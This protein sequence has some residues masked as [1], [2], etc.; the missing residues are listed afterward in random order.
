[1][2]EENNIPDEP[3]YIDTLEIENV[4]RVKA[5][6]IKC[7]DKA[8]TVVG[9]RN[10]QGKSTT[11]DSVAYA[12][13]GERFRPT[14]FRRDGALANPEIK[15]TLSNGLI[16]ERKGKNADLKVTDP[17]GALF[18]QALLKEIIPLFALDLPRFMNSTSKEKA[19]ILLQIIGIGDELTRLDEKEQ[20]LYNTRHSHGQDADRKRKYADELPTYPD[21]PHI[22]V[23]ASELIK[24]QQDILA[25]NGENKKKREKVDDLIKDHKEAVSDVARLTKELADAEQELANLTRDLE[26][27]QKTAQELEDESTAEIEEKLNEIDAINVKVRA[28]MDKDKANEEAEEKKAE[29]D[30]MTEEIEAVRAT[31][32]KLLEGVDLPLPG[33]SVENSELTYNGKAWDCMGSAEQL[34]VST[35][36]VRRLNPKCGFALI[37]GLE[38]MDL[39]TLHEF[40]KWLQGEGFK[41]LGTRVSEGD[42][43]SIIIEDGFSID[44]EGKKDFV[45]GEF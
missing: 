33:L 16:V 14:N 10:G 1:M 11:V 30:R 44:E 39:K 35:A 3:V 21:A 15:V 23:T 32:L 42:E 41:I 40:G 20:R 8:L 45:Y 13:G 4:K 34:R 17:N 25:R 24:A 5:V 9:G 12:L 7:S 28:N 19:K 29:Y 26:T 27:A 31:K 43:C 6:K 2:T 38:S 37:D 18:G 22:P 36:I